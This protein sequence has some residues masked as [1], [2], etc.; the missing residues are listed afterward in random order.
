MPPQLSPQQPIVNPF[1]KKH[2]QSVNSNIQVND[3]N[4]HQT[5]TMN[6]N[7]AL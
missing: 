7:S 2:F 6:N 4:N 3:F 1:T 5:S